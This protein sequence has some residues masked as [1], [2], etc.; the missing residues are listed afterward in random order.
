M[1]PAEIESLAP[2]IGFLTT[3]FIVAIPVVAFSARFAIKPIADAVARLRESQGQAAGSEAM[4]QLQDRR[5]SLLEAELQAIHGTLERL[6]EAERFRSEL[7][8]SRIPAA[9]PASPD[10]AH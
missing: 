10:R 3:A 8:A 5:M 6:V 1:T 2:L 9:L 7:E 4:L